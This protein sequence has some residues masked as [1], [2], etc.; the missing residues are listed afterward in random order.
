MPHLQ[1][2]ADS[3]YTL[4]PNRAPKTEA[5]S[6]L[7]QGLVDGNV[8][9]R[10]VHRLESSPEYIKDRPQLPQPVF[11]VMRCLVASEVQIA[12]DLLISLTRHGRR[13]NLLM[14]P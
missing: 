9:S 10:C 3:L 14:E 7:L 13:V 5:A 8:L 12:R 11:L 4:T 1:S 6:E 2:L